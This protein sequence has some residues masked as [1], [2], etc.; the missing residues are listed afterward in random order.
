M[1]C[2][3]WVVLC[4]TSVYARGNIGFLPHRKLWGSYSLCKSE[5]TLHASTLSSQYCPHSTGG[6]HSSEVDDSN[7]LNGRTSSLPTQRPVFSMIIPRHCTGSPSLTCTSLPSVLACGSGKVL[8]AASAQPPHALDQHSS[9]RISSWDYTTCKTVAFTCFYFL[10]HASA[11][12]ARR[13]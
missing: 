1:G 2:G 4:Q 5:D 12:N 8:H 7:T 9:R 13:S 6:R 3:T 10:G 11:R